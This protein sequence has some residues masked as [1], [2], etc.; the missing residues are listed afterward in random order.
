V[1]T[2]AGEPLPQEFLMLMPQSKPTTVPV[3]AGHS[4]WA[5]VFRC[6]LKSIVGIFVLQ[7]K[8]HEFET[9]IFTQ[10]RSE[11]KK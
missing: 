9:N 5:K 7:T 1:S 10:H 2:F 6:K 4:A 11:M 3:I 8:Q